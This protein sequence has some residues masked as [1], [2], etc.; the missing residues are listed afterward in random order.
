MSL[1]NGSLAAWCRPV[2]LLLFVS[3]HVIWLKHT[4]QHCHFWGR[5][6]KTAS[7]YSVKQMIEVMMVRCA[8]QILQCRALQSIIWILWAWNRWLSRHWCGANGH[9]LIFRWWMDVWWAFKDEAYFPNITIDNDIA[10]IA[11]I[12]NAQTNI[13]RMAEDWEEAS[14][15]WINDGHGGRPTH[16]H[17]SATIPKKPHTSATIQVSH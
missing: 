12:G 1:T 6:T 8:L 5:K 4:T 16:K 13:Q 3:I 15:E 17:T 7:A 14:L 11:V 10:D 2:N 9:T